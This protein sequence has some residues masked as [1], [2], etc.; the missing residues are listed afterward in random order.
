M[1]SYGYVRDNPVAH[2]DPTG[3]QAQPQD[4]PPP[5]DP[6]AQQQ[7]LVPPPPPTETPHADVGPFRLYDPPKLS[8]AP[9]Q[10]EVQEL[11]LTLPPFHITG[12][13]GSLRA[14][15]ERR[16]TRVSAR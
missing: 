16:G 2:S 3:Q 12:G 4:P 5:Q 8:L 15:M 10:H 11:G 6:L 1:N 14:Y 7:P 9:G 13:V